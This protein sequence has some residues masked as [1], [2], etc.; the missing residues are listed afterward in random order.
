[1]TGSLEA[2]VR[3]WGPWGLLVVGLVLLV[4]LYA[5]DRIV[6]AGRYRE[7]LADR[8]F[9]RDLSMSALDVAEAYAVS[10]TDTADS[11]ER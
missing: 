9:W 3:L 5:T 1:M 2:L 8:D 11:T 7:L 6:S 4:W 10:S